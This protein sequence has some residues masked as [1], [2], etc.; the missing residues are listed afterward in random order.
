MKILKENRKRYNISITT[1]L[2]LLIFYILNTIYFYLGIRKDK[3][4]KFFFENLK[5][6][7]QQKFYFEKISNIS[8]I[9]TNIEYLLFFS[10]L[11]YLIILSIK[12]KQKKDDINMSEYLIVSI[13]TLLSIKIISNI[14]SIIFSTGNLTQQT[15]LV[16]AI[17]IPVLIYFLL[18]RIYI[19][20]Y[21][22]LTQKN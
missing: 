7:E 2:Y 14:L 4:A 15:I 22:S 1:K 5:Y 9:T 16:F 19:K 17:T 10:N 6:K 11:I 13:I 18:K 20:I 12:Y 8:N 3:L 21:T